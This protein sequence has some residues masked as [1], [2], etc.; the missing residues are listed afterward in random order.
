MFTV[1]SGLILYIHSKLGGSTKI[2]IQILI[3]T[4][5]L[6]EI[7]LQ[8]TQMH[9]HDLLSNLP[10]VKLR[11]GITVNLGLPVNKRDE[12]E[13]PNCPVIA[14]LDN[15]KCTDKSHP[16]GVTIPNATVLFAH[17]RYDNFKRQWVFENG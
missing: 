7:S 13:I 9:G 10:A 5:E 6:V 16:T 15:L 3:M 2:F 14:T 4:S 8:E 12:Y 1:N 11:E 17:G